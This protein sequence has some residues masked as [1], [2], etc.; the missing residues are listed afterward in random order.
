MLSVVEIGEKIAIARKMKNL[1]QSQLATS[2][3]VSAQAV[4]KWERGESMPDIIMFQNL[5]ETLG[6]DLNYF[7]GGQS[8]PAE[9]QNITNTQAP[10][11][12][13]SAKE[14]A[15][16]QIP[17]WNMSSSNWKD[18]DFSGLGGLAEKFN[19]ANIDN[20]QFVDSELS[21]LQLRRN[22]INYSDFTK[23][24]LK[25]CTFSN[26]NIQN[27]VFID[28]DLSK[29]EFIRSN[30]VESD[31]TGAN[32][33]GIAAKWC[34]IRRSIFKGAS[35]SG[36]LFNYCQFTDI[37]FDGKIVNCAFENND[38]TRVEFSGAEIR[39]TFF[40]NCKLKKAKII[41]CKMDKLTYA[42]M[43]AC[44]ADLSDV[45]MLED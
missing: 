21:G 12:E 11:A 25:G 15:A 39:N 45:Q 44:K 16:V 29:S 8:S 4:G 17:E 14:E 10:M 32:L 19:N 9:N 18:M 2:L 34:N 24:D 40:K 5:A 23:S 1:S 36:A 38:F 26:A 7:S 42:F 20:C 28:C 3:S 27:D 31:F 22:N 30:V 41:N 43:K 6:V 33:T 37:V 35:L 13:I